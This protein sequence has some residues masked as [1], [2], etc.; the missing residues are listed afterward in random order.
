MLHMYIIYH[1]FGM[2]L[3]R[4]VNCMRSVGGVDLNAR[5]FESLSLTVKTFNF[6]A[7]FQC[8]SSLL[9]SFPA[10]SSGYQYH[11]LNDSTS[12]RPLSKFFLLHQFCSALC[13]FELV[14]AKY[15]FSTSNWK[16]N[17]KKKKNCMTDAYLDLENHKK[18]KFL[19][20]LTK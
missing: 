6:A 13:I 7:F 2:S 8:A 19:E 16:G 3:C 1:C 4:N 10:L 14:H 11:V 12:L 20:F 17:K 5:W 9:N 15:L 18:D